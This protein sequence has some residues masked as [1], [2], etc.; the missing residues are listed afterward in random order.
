MIHC[1]L[2]DHI[3][4][5]LSNPHPDSFNAGRSKDVEQLVRA[6]QDFVH[7]AEDEGEV[8]DSG[9]SSGSGPS[10]PPPHPRRKTQNNKRR[11]NKR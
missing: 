1:H 3:L 5:H 8:S 10:A 2:T 6:A 7:E 9:R 4:K 11:K